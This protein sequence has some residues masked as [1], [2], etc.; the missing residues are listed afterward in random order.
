MVDPF[1]GRFEE[2]G[3]VDDAHS[4]VFAGEPNRQQVLDRR[5]RVPAF[6]E[7]TQSADHQEAAAAVTHEGLGEPQLLGREPG[8]LDISENDGVIGKQLLA[9]PR[10]PRRQLLFRIADALSVDPPVR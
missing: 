6:P 10:V 1:R 9:V 8:R 4:P 7:G 2:K 5:S 3:V